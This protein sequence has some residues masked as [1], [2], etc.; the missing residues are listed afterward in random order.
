MELLIGAYHKSEYVG[1]VEEIIR[2]NYPKGV[3]SLM[4]ELPSNYP[5][6]NCRVQEL[7]S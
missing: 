2:E 1:K 7:M 4:V 6:L 3:K 5:L